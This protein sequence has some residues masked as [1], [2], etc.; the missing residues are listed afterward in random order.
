MPRI[1][2]A[3]RDLVLDR[4]G[5]EAPPP[6]TL[7]GLNRL[8]GAWCRGVPFDNLRKLIALAANDPG[9]LPG[10]CARDFFQ[11]WLAHGT[12]GTCWPSA[13][14]LFA[15][16]EACGFDARRASASMRD[17]GEPNHGSVFVRLDGDDWLADTAML[18]GR[19]F[20]LR[21]GEASVTGDP[22]SPL[23]VEPVD[24]SWR[25]WVRFAGMDEPLSRHLLD[26]CVDHAFFL[27][28]YE[29]T[30]EE[31]PFNSALYAARNGEGSRVTWMNTTR[32][33]TT[34]EGTVRDI[35]SSHQLAASLT[36]EL[37]LSREMLRRLVEGGV[38]AQ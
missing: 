15:L 10:G 37:R 11:S 17:T 25:I 20:P 5:L 3:L 7:D 32:I 36:R 1:D 26:D 8:Y 4:L 6:V 19:V 13:N 30:R 12:G 21:K 24:D 27:A 16:I 23:R 29:R 22:L 14:G 33:V 2:R 31:S 28:R 35:L 9:P 38:L 34:R 18:S